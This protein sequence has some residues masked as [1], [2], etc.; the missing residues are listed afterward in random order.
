[1]DSVQPFL[2]FHFGPL[3]RPVLLF[4]FL[5]ANAFVGLIVPG[6]RRELPLLWRISEKLTAVSEK[7]LNRARRSA[8]TRAIRGFL[9]ALLMTGLALLLAKAVQKLSDGWQHGWLAEFFLLA[10]CVSFATPVRA[11]IA[12]ASDLRSGQLAQAWK[13]LDIFTPWHGHGAGDAHAPARA[14]VGFSAWALNRCVV[15]PGLWFL[16]LGPQGL[17]VYVAVASADRV[18]NYRDPQAEIFGRT[19]AILDDVLNYVPA[20]FSALLAICGAA[21]VPRARVL[22]AI[23]ETVDFEDKRSLNAGLCLAAVAGATGVALTDIQRKGK[24]HTGLVW[25]GGKKATAKAR[26]EDVKISVKILA[27]SVLVFMATLGG[28]IWSIARFF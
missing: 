13:T 14:A 21:L 8:A 28:V 12:V 9:F 3:A 15:G 18:M 16:I 10:A 11:L 17:C 19:T 1:M 4:I 25:I 2:D 24:N 5:A 26:W 6:R 27:A 20:R 22:A 7:R 23:K